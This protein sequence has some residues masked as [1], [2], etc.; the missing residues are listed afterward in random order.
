MGSVHRILNSSRRFH[1]NLPCV[2]FL[3]HHRSVSCLFL[4]I[5]VFLFHANLLRA[6][7]FP[8][9]FVPFKF[10]LFVC[11]SL[12]FVSCESVVCSAVY[13]FTFL[14]RHKF[15]MQ[16][17]HCPLSKTSA[18]RKTEATMREQVL[19]ATV[20]HSSGGKWNQSIDVC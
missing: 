16:N 1:W 12:F 19:S 10:P 8:S 18:I 9:S 11:I 3:Y 4:Y 7:P 14:F 5:S 20:I 15:V 2:T 17:C 13:H 6:A